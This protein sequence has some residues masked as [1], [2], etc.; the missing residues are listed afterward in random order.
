[1]AKAGEM[2]FSLPRNVCC[3]L[4]GYAAQKCAGDQDWAATILLRIGLIATGFLPSEA[5]IGPAPATPKPKLRKD[6]A[7]WLPSRTRKPER[8]VLIGKETRR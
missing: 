5:V 1:M 2:F 7:G 8:K 6:R 3:G 4:I